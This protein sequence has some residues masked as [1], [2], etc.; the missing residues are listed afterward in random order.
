MPSPVIGS[1]RSSL[2]FIESISCARSAPTFS[3]GPKKPSSSADWKYVSATEPTS[4]AV[5]GGGVAAETSSVPSG[6]NTS[7][8][9]PCESCVSVKP[10]FFG[11]LIVVSPISTWRV[12]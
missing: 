8:P 5:V 3:F 1:M 2:P 4:V 10:V 11:P 7:E 6:E 9:M 12:L